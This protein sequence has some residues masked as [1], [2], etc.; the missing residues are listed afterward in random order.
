MEKHDVQMAKA[1]DK[2]EPGR[3]DVEAMKAA[4][5][6]RRLHWTGDLGR[7][8]AASACLARFLVLQDRRRVA[9]EKKKKES[10]DELD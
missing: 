4:L 6:E 8:T 1:K 10:R 2:N 3:A 5:L 7:W 9:A